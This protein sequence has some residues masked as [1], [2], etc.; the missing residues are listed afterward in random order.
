MK[1]VGHEF[2]GRK[3]MLISLIDQQRDELAY[4]AS[5]LRNTSEKVETIVKQVKYFAKPLSS[6]IFAISF[7]RSKMLQNSPS[8]NL[9]KYS[10]VMFFLKQSIRLIIARR[11][12]SIQK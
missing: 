9:K 10:F 3:E 6:L 7:F 8:N 11:N 5:P 4:Y 2:Q 12:R 1:H